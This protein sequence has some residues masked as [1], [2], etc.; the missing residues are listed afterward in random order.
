MNHRYLRNVT[1]LSLNRQKCTGC[2]RCVEVCPHE[3]FMLKNKKAEIIEKDLCMECGACAKNCPVGAIS[4][5]QG[6][7]CAYAIIIGKL[8][9]TEPSCDCTGNSTDDRNGNSN[10]KDG[11]GNSSDGGSSVNNSCC[12]N[13]INNNDNRDNSF[14][15][16]KKGRCC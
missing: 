10:Y 6:V 5:K 4:V 9:G 7:G 16:A 3:V 14:K 8:M 15:S 13:S 1:T 11:S 12:S 2:G